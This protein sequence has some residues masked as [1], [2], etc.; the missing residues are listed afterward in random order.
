MRCCRRAGRSP[1]HVSERYQISVRHTGEPPALRFQRIAM[2]GIVVNFNR[3]ATIYN[4]NICAIALLFVSWI[5]GCSDSRKES[6]TPPAAPPQQTVQSTEPSKTAAAAIRRVLDGLRQQNAR[7]VWEFLPPSYRAEIQELVRDVAKQ[8]DDDT[9][10]AIVAVWQ[11]ARKVL[12]AK[13][14]AI[15]GQA[16]SENLSDNRSRPMVNP[17]SL[18][19]LFD[20]V[21]D[22]ELAD[23]K[24]LRQID[25]GLFFEKTGG[26][27]LQAL[28]ALPTDGAIS[29]KSFENLAKVEVTLVSTSGDSAI[30]RM[31]WPDQDP[32]EHAYVRVEDHWLPKTLAEG[33]SESL[34][35]IRVQMVAW[36]VE[37]KQQPNAWSSQLKAVDQLLDELAATKSDDDARTVYQRG[38]QRLVAT[39]LGT[40]SPAPTQSSPTPS[41][42]KRK[43]PDTEELLPDEK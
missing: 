37:F 2:K 16:I 15:F 7:A 9:W 38:M 18:Q 34:A 4:L 20:S 5:V 32:T 28:G 13:S 29:S 30:V 35:N 40:P 23:L 39:W 42:K 43:P 6:T 26:D 27:V 25:V 8:L 22:S 24:R 1:A 14:A 33:W 19:R 41:A 21:G 31:K 10:E 17:E 12:P 36:T 3:K 11:K